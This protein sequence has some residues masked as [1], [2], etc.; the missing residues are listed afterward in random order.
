MAKILINII[1]KETIPN[2]HAYKEIQPDILIQ[3][4]SDFSKKA[5]SILASMV[6]GELTEV[7]SIECDGWNFLDL[8]KRLRQNIKL[9]PNDQLFLNVTGG[10]KMMALPVYEFAKEQSKDVEAKLFY[11]TTDSKVVW[12]LNKDDVSDLQSVLSIQELIT[13]Q[14]QK[15]KSKINYDE[16]ISLFEKP[17]NVIKTEWESKNSRWNQFLKLIKNLFRQSDDEVNPSFESFL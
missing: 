2:F 3:V 17:L 8:L 15:L 4:F 1:G 6:N 13:L 12:F 9:L 14:D 5:A 16:I 7:V 10:T 11:T